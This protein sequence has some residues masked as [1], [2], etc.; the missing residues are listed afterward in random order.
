[1]ESA[2]VEIILLIFV[3]VVLYIIFDNI[4]LSV[5]IF[6]I[7]AYFYDQQSPRLTTDILENITSA[8]HVVRTIKTSW[9]RIFGKIFNGEHH[10]IRVE[11]DAGNSYVIHNAG[12]RGIIATNEKLMSK[13][14]KVVNDLIV[15]GTKN[16]AGAIKAG[17]GYTNNW[18]ISFVT[19]GSCIGTAN[20][21]KEFLER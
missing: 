10:G 17:S 15:V 14:W 12:I 2:T 6:I 11:T 4:I 19:A 16:I 18:I 5:L 9:M 20:S 3:F 7:I 13:K 1:M 8:Q 21:I